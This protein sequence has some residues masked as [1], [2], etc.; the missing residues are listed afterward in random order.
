MSW[1]DTVGGA[2]VV[3]PLREAG[4]LHGLPEVFALHLDSDAHLGNPRTHTFAD[5]VAQRLLAGRA[6]HIGLSAAAGVDLKEQRSRLSA[7]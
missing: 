5:A 4:P 3:R 7:D 6:L 1:S 2:E